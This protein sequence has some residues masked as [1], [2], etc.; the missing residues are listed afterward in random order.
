MAQVGSASASSNPEEAVDPESLSQKCM[1]LQDKMSLLLKTLQVESEAGEKTSSSTTMVRTKSF[2]TLE[3]ESCQC[4]KSCRSHSDSEITPSE[5]IAEVIPRK[6][7]KP[8]VTIPKE[9][10]WSR[11]NS[12][13]KAMREIISHTEKGE[14]LA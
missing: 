9:H 2:E 6:K 1:K 3:E 13:K 14:I 8:K 7:R 5:A 12:L 11:A 4:D 10:L